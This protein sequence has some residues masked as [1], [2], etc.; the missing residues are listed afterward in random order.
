MDLYLSLNLFHGRKADSRK[1]GNPPKAVALFSALLAPPWSIL[2][3]DGGAT[4]SSPPF[5]SL[6]S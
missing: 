1:D 2:Y 5:N 3:L 6:K 4:D